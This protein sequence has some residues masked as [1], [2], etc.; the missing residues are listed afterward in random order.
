[1]TKKDKVAN[2]L[3]GLGNIYQSRTQTCSNICRQVAFALTAVTWAIIFTSDYGEKWQRGHAKCVLFLLV[4][5]F[6]IDILQ[7]FFTA[8]C[9]KRRHSIVVHKKL[10]HIDFTKE[11]SDEEIN[12]KLENTDV[13]K[14]CS[15]E[16]KAKRKINACSYRLFLMKIII[17]VISVI[18]M[19]YLVIKNIPN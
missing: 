13:E 16:E 17:L 3:E 5:Y 1:M 11:E 18:G 9:Y 7:Y 12:E 6:L 2:L 4:F 19:M 15:D 14:I 8:I 10:K